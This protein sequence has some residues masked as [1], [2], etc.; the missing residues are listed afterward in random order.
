MYS[1]IMS[2]KPNKDEILKFSTM[3]DRLAIELDTTILDAVVH[4]CEDTGLEIEVAGTLLSNAI[5][6]KIREQSEKVNL[7]KKQSRLPV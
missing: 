3:I 5:K 2:T 4:H 1:V 6:A 7:V